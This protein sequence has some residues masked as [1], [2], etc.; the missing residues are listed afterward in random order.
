MLSLAGFSAARRH[1]LFRHGVCKVERLL[2]RGDIGFLHGCPAGPG[3]SGGPLFA[4][5]GGARVAY[6][7]MAPTPVR[8]VAVERALEGQSLDARGIT[9]ALAVA[10]EGCAPATDAIASDWYRREVAPV[11]LRRVLLGETG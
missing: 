10:T 5:A 4:W 6:G 7:G 3:H 1:R 9:A 2:G 11:H 8:A